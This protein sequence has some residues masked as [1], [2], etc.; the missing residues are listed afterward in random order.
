MEDLIG[1]GVCHC[2]KQCAEAL[3][4]SHE[5]TCRHDCRNDG[6]EDVPQ[7]LDRLLERVHLLG[8]GCLHV[9]LGCRFNAGQRHELVVHPID[10][11][12]PKDDLK[13]S[14]CD[15]HAFYAID[16]FNL[17]FL[18]LLFVPYHKTEPCSTVCAGN[19]VVLSADFFQHLCCG[20]SVIHMAHLLY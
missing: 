6:N 18:D 11:A 20:F 1:V 19:Q 2:G 9:L 10:N 15:E 8:G 4:Q 5:Q 7:R 17:L 12:C 14:L 16:L 3:Q 13:L